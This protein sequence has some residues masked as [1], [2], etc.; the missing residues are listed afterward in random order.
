MSFLEE[1]ALAV[2]TPQNEFA[3]RVAAIKKGRSGALN[4]VTDSMEKG[5]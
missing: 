3:H 4:L 2:I 5:P 1:D